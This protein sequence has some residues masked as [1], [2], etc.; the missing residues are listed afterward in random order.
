MAGRRENNR[1]R[2]VAIACIAFVALMVGAAYAAVPLYDL[3]CRVTGYGGTTQVADA[4]SERV[5]DRE[6]TVRFDANVSPALPWAFRPEVRSVTLKLGESRIVNY[7]AENTGSARNV[8]TA[9]FNV[10]PEQ[11]GAYFN[12]IAC[13]CFTEQW[14][15][16][17][18]RVEMPVEFFVSPDLADDPAL[19]GV[20]TITLSYTFFPAER[21]EPV[22]QAPLP[23]AERAERDPAAL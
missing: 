7:V 10:T 20:E 3:F 12:K 22:A 2:A 13:F 16:P 21:A 15:D 8:G 4:A 5:L 14:L 19:D 18:E 17:G 1:N 11:T 9:T 6:I 23:D